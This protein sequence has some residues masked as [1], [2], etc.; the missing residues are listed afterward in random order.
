MLLVQYVNVIVFVENDSITTVDSKMAQLMAHTKNARKMTNQLFN[1]KDDELAIVA[2]G[3]YGRCEK[4]SNN[5]FQYKTYRSQKKD[6][7][8]KPF[9]VSCANGYI[10][11]Y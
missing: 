9:I 4:S 10:I 5:D 7:L 3:T 1:L 2:D 6:S 11:E 8:I